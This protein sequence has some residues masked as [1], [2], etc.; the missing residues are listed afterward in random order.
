LNVEDEKNLEIISLV[1]CIVSLVSLCGV[2]ATALISK[3]WLRGPGQKILLQMAINLALLLIMYLVAAYAKAQGTGCM[4]IGF[5]LHYTILSNFLWM[6]VAGYLQYYRLVRIF[7]SRTTKLVLKSA[8][9][10]W[11]VPVIPGLVLLSTEQYNSET[12]FCLPKKEWILHATMIAPVCIVLVFNIVIFIMIVKNLYMT[13]RPRQHV[14]KCISIR[15]FKQLAFLFTLLG[16]NWIFGVSQIAF[17]DL[18]VF[19]AYLFCITI[20]FQGMTYFVFF[21]LHEKVRDSWELLILYF[22]KIKS[23]VDAEGIT[24]DTVTESVSQSK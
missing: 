10:G 2:F 12:R 22:R 6:A 17:P 21:V 19:F 23:N 1:G 13:T 24:M 3:K 4:I 15:R 7:S 8:I 18:S 9:V 11:V 20:T 14:D 5:F 16:L